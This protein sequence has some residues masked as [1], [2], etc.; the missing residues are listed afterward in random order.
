[1]KKTVLL[2]FFILLAAPATVAD[3]VRLSVL[4][5]H[6]SVGQQMVEARCEIREAYLDTMNIIVGTDTARISFRSYHT[7]YE[8]YHGALSDTVAPFCRENRFPPSFTYDLRRTSNINRTI[9]WDPWQGESGLLANLFDKP[10]K[11]DSAFWRIFTTHNIPGPVDSIPVKYDI[12]IFK[13]PYST[14]GNVNQV[15]ADTIRYFYRTV[16]DSIAQHPEINVGLMFGTPLRQQTGYDSTNAKYVYELASWFASDEFFTHSNTGPYKNVWKLDTY[17]QLCETNASINKYCLA[18]NMWFGDAG[19][20]LSDLAA[21]MSQDTLAGF[22]RQIARD[23]L[24]QRNGLIIDTVGPVITY[25]PEDVSYQC[26]ADLPVCDDGMIVVTD[27]FDSDPEIECTD[28]YQD[29]IITRVW[30]A[31]DSSGNVSDACLQTITIEDFEAPVINCPAD[32]TIQCGQS[33]SA[34]S[35]GYATATDNCDPE[36]TVEYTDVKDGLVITRSWNATDSV[37]NVSDPCLQTITIETPVIESVTPAS[38]APGNILTLSIVGTNTCFGAGSETIV[39]LAAGATIITGTSVMAESSTLVTAS[40]DIPLG[41]PT[42]LYDVEIEDVG[43]VT[44]VKPNGFMVGEGWTL[45]INAEGVYDAYATYTADVTI[46]IAEEESLVDAPPAPIDYT[47]L[48]TLSRANGSGPYVEDIRTGDAQTY[49]WI[50]NINPHGTVPPPDARCATISWDPLELDAASYYRLIDMGLDGLGSDIVVTDMRTTTSYEV[51]GFDQTHYYAI[52]NLNTDH[53]LDVTLVAGWQLI[54]LPLIPDDNNLATL[55][56]GYQAAWGYDNA[57]RQYEQVTQLYPCEGYWLKMAADV[58]VTVCGQP[59]TDCSGPLVPG[60]HILGGPNCVITPQ[61]APPGCL[62]AT[63]E[64]DPDIDDYLIPATFVPAAGYWAMMDNTSDMLLDCSAAPR[65]GL[66]ELRPEITASSEAQQ[67]TL[68]AVGTDLEG[69]SQAE[70]VIGIDTLARTY[71]AAPPPPV[72]SVSMMAY[73]PDWSGPY[74]RDIRKSGNDT[75]HWII[76]VNPHGNAEPPGTRTATLSWDPSELSDEC[77]VLRE[78]FEGTGP[79]VV[80]DMRQVGEYVVSGTNSQ[81][82]FTLTR[83]ASSSTGVVPST[84]Y[85]NQCYPNPFNPVTLIVFGI[86]TANRVQLTI[87]NNLG[88]TVETVIDDHLEAGEY[89]I[90]WDGSKFASGVYFYRLDAGDYSQTRKMVLLK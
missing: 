89:K 27:N 32:V 58:I 2:I 3:E 88:R 73:Q 22:I 14:W 18:N 74:Y 50:L 53:C 82:Y 64:Y 84:F 23:I 45:S 37:G 48:M 68:R 69:T 44:A 9:I 12:V 62:I 1:M 16:C 80:E 13:N 59:L 81:Y 43:V 33:V 66:G 6:Y 77:Y 31:T 19:S 25:C 5:V 46:G 41:A 86:P 36:V 40:F 42:G 4:Y 87:Y 60:W 51:C 11:E 49:R 90:Q 39:R 28:I 75:D 83:T 26:L 76:A 55:F 17:R 54:S 38:A 79:V 24:I 57:S 71:P 7:N 67:F 20:H 65:P 8:I 35:T 30:I 70:I 63:W 72:Y 21:E 56:P 29:N 47:V 10:H 52:E 34:D 15:Y 61:T 78:G 85:L